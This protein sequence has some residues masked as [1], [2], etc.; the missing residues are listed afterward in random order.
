[1]TDQKIIKKEANCRT[2]SG[3]VKSAKNDK[4]I[5]VSV[6]SAKIH[7]KY[8]KRY[9]THKSYKV[10]DEEN[11]FQAGDKVSFS[12]CRPLSRDKRWRV[13]YPKQ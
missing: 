5:V 3:V 12:E 6:G 9:T 2:L 11:R 8:K 7:P 10:H 13:I 4:T 1:M